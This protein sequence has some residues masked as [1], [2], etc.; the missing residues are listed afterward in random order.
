M[1]KF[2]NIIDGINYQ[3]F[4]IFCSSKMQMGGPNI[5][6]FNWWNNAHKMHSII[7]ELDSNSIEIELETD[8]I[9]NVNEHKLKQDIFTAE[10]RTPVYTNFSLHTP[11]PKSGTIMLRIVMGC[12]KCDM[13]S[14]ILQ[15][16]LSMDL[17][18]VTDVFLNFER[19]SFKYSDTQ[20]GCDIKNLY[21]MSKTVFVE[22]DKNSLDG[23][24]ITELPLIPMNI[25][26][27]EETLKR[28][29]NLLIFS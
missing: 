6:S 12:N 13:Y 2:R 26:E 24:K 4:C 8:Q 11:V 5:R 25:H 21:G 29:K 20:R 28:V 16:C 15:I 22:F 3:P 18:A 19:I 7:F 17:R 9:I 14:Y 23:D 1:K 27:P 10:G